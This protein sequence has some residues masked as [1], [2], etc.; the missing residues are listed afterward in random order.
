[1]TGA[2][3]DVARAMAEARRKFEL[4]GIPDPGRDASALFLSVAEEAVG[5]GDTMPPDV[6]VAYARA[7]ARRVAREPVS[8]I[9]GRRAFWMHD[10]EVTP[11][12]LDPRPDTETLVEE[13]CAVP[14][15][16]ILDLGTGSGCVLLSILYERPGARG[17]G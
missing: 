12:V 7:V 3:T 4:V 9:T 8:H 2:E 5:S 13:A 15:R 17:T 14:F 11:D 10:F 1:M 16:Q 6:A